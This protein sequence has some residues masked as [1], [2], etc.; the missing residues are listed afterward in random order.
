MVGGVKKDLNSKAAMKYSDCL[1]ITS[2][3][4]ALIH[5]KDKQ[6]TSDAQIS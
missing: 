2:I 1:K 5:A 4:L 3:T 6:N